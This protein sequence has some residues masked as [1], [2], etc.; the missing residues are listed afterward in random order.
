MK[1]NGFRD[2]VRVLMKFKTRPCEAYQLRVHPQ[3]L[4][5]RRSTLSKNGWRPSTFPRVVDTPTFV[6]A[7][8][9]GTLFHSNPPF[10]C[11]ANESL[12]LLVLPSI[13]HNTRYVAL[14]TF[15]YPKVAR[16]VRE[17]TKSL[18]QLGDC[19]TFIAKGRNHPF[20]RYR[21]RLL[22]KTASR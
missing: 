11:R 3:R 7:N 18:V 2:G 9:F 15:T 22:V 16:N 8:S 13:R 14:R 1:R 19:D 20:I 10:V 6:V 17:R 21:D 5:S 4:W 12:P